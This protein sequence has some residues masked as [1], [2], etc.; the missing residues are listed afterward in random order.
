MLNNVFEVLSVYTK[1]TP[2]YHSLLCGSNEDVSLLEARVAA[3][4][5][6]HLNRV[7]PG[8]IDIACVPSVMNTTIKIKQQ[9]EGHARQVLMAAFGAHLDYNKVCIVVDEDINIFD[10]RFFGQGTSTR[11]VSPL[12]KFCNICFILFNIEKR[13]YY[14]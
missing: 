2:T 14:M 1:P 7:V 3:K 10:L 9:Y 13:K 12:D 6:R 11:D 8:I 4:T 5:F